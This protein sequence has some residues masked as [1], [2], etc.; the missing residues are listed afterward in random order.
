MEDYIFIDFDGVI[1][2]SE[3]RMLERKYKLGFCDHKN[4]EEFNKYFEYTCSHPEEWDYIIRE[5]NSINSSVE[6]IKE[7]EILKQKIAILTKIH[8]FYEMQVKIEDLREHRKITSPIIFVPPKIK[9]YQVVVPNNQ[10]LID[11]SEKNIYEW[12]NNGGKGLIFD[13]KIENET[14]RKV[15]S[16]NF[17]NKHKYY[18][19]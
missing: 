10:L 17:L 18:G 19:K 12:I 2:D 16:L 11:D 13:S 5:A 9:K 14:K 7:L 3:E 1:L 4:K 15:K 6:I 8:T